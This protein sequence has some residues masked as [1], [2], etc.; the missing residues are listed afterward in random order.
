MVLLTGV[1]AGLKGNLGQVGVT[2]REL[3]RHAGEPWAWAAFFEPAGTVPVVFAVAAFG[4]AQPDSLWARLFY[5]DAKLKRAR[6]R[7]G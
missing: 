4:L 3:G 1:V 2:F 6:E 5:R 7:F